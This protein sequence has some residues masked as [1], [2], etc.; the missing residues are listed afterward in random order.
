MASMGGNLCQRVRCALLPRRRLAVQQARA[1]HGLLGARR[2]QPRPRDPRHERPLHRDASLGRRG[3]ARRLR[4]RRPHDG[5]G[6]RA[7]RSRSTTS[8]CFPATR[9]RLEHPLE[10]GELITAIEL[11]AAAARARSLY[12]KFRDRQSYEFALVSVAA[13]LEVRD[14]DGH[15]RRASRSAASAPSRGARAAPR[16]SCR[17]AGRRRAVRRAPRRR[18]SRQRSRA[19]TTRSRSSSPQRAIV[20]ALTTATTRRC[21]MTPA[22]GRPVDRVDGREKVTGA[23]PLLGRDPA[24]RARPRRHRRRQLSPSG[25]VAAIDADD[26]LAADGVLAVLTHENLPRIAGRAAPAPL[27]GRRPGS[28]A[29]ASSRCRTTSCTTPASRWRSSSPTATSARSTRRRWSTS[30]YERRRRSRRST[31]GATPP[32]RPSGSSAG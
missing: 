25:R 26:A 18:S 30:S 3:R 21:A 9:R 7:R 31:R 29:R 14:G 11:P 10:H 32:T 23:R 16:R 4:R 2:A 20:R 12:L 22:I 15:G 6:G 28:R 17:G 19:R 8:T 5:P 1:G 13:A 24:A 27:A